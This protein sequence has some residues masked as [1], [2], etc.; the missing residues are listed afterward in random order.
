MKFVDLYFITA[1]GMASKIRTI[2]LYLSLLSI[3][4]ITGLPPLYAQKETKNAKKSPQSLKAEQEALFINALAERLTGNIKESHEKF[5]AFTEKYPDNATAWFQLAELESL[6]GRSSKTVEYLSKS[7]KI[8]DKNK[9]FRLRLGEEYEAIRQF[10]EARKVYEALVKDFPD[11]QDFRYDVAE[12]YSI[13][14]RLEDAAKVYN[15]IERKFGA[16]E[17]LSLKKHRLY[18]MIGSPKEAKREVENLI[19][20][21]PSEATYYGMLAEI[22]LSM[23]EEKQALENYYKVLDADP[24]NTIVHLS[25]SD[26][27]QKKGMIDKS[28]YHLETAFLNKD[29]EIDSKVRILLSL[30]ELSSKSEKYR[31]EGVKLV[32]MLVKTHPDNPRS[33]SMMGDV[34]LNNK[35][36]PCAEKSFRQVVALEK[37]KFVIWDQLLALQARMQ[38]WNQSVAYADTALEFFPN[39]PEIYLYKGTALLNLGRYIDASETLLAGQMIVATDKEMSCRFA[40]CLGDVYSAWKKNSE[41]NTYYTEALSLDPGNQLVRSRFALH[42]ASGGSAEQAM[43]MAEEARTAAPGSVT[44]EYNYVQT[45]QALGK[46]SE[47]ISEIKQFFTR[48]GDKSPLLW[49]YLGDLYKISGNKTEA[50]EAWSKARS[51]SDFPKPSLLRKLNETN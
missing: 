50:L 45:L 22:L 26:Y 3:L 25:L 9:W 27:Y 51:L 7:I 16:S 41:A 33:Y 15:D 31:D 2:S 30:L 42:K 35:D 8:D 28:F 12:I 29:V 36:I 5:E 48:Q 49:E 1:P 40:A 46:T 6:L 20:L 18:L 4:M 24:L 47:A 21:N 34:C 37:S 13:E 14:E 39:S 17:E 32:D 43:A 11:D 38:E 23:G 44:V 19:R 10:A